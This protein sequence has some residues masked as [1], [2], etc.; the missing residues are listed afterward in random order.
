MKH[1]FIITFTLLFFINSFGIGQNNK[2]NFNTSIIYKEKIKKKIPE[3]NKL[4][5]KKKKYWEKS[6]KIFHR[7]SRSSK[8]SNCNPA[9]LAINS[10]F[11]Y[12]R[13]DLMD[14][15]ANFSNKSLS[16]QFLM[17]YFNSGNQLSNSGLDEVNS[18]LENL[19]F[20]LNLEINP[21]RIEF[22]KMMLSSNINT[23]V[24]GDFKG[25]ILAIPFSSL[26]L[27]YNSNQNLNT[28]ALSFVKNSIGLG[29]TFKTNFATFRVGINYNYLMG[30]IY[31]KTKSDTFNFVNNI[32]NVSSNLSFSMEGNKLI[33]DSI[34]DSVLNNNDNQYFSEVS[35]GYDLGLGVNLKKIIHQNL[36]I[37]L[38][39]E[40]IGSSITFK[41]G[42]KK[43][44]SA[45]ISAN[46]LIDF[47]DSLSSTK[48]DTISSSNDITIEIPLKTFIKATYQPIP[49]IVVSGGFEK[50]SK[51][52]LTNNS[53]PIICLNGAIYPLNWYNLNYGIRTKN[54]QIIQI[55]G[56][57][58]QSKLMDL[59]VEVS[60][61]D[62]ILNNSNGIGIS[63]RLSFYL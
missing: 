32:S 63:F 24:N 36:D 56:A 48:I 14:L 52:F 19:N 35:N 60:S 6:N 46:N 5:R 22:G 40:N 55:L 38:F 18:S 2:T 1:N 47:S 10:P 3:K 20:M 29:R 21:L 26:N 53:K 9:N 54:G 59:L 27:G 44:Y 8:L 11:Y 7:F 30:L 31:F 25:K 57:G 17:D 13:F 42:T 51:D 49:Q 43:T 41:N 39:I 4:N 62:G 16:P 34:N 50:Y 12:F 61:Y 33:W 37:E 15:E 23:M 58:I 45:N 28:E